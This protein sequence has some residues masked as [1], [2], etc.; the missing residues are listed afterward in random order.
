MLLSVNT[1]I[2]KVYTGDNMSGLCFHSP[3]GLKKI[4]AC[5]F[6]AEKLMM[7]SEI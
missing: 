5:S 7:D 3:S 1:I 4:D 2:N 6:I